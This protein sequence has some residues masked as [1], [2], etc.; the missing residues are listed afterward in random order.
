MEQHHFIY[1]ISGTNRPSSNTL[2]ITRSLERHDQA[3]GVTVGM[4]SLEALPPE[5]FAPAAYRAKPA[6]FV[7]IQ[8]KVLAS[9]GMHLVVPEY[10][11]SFPGALKYFIDMLK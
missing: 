5:L 2:R 11:G 3:A 4:F 10:N 9:A 7:E 8:Q 1:L 6:A